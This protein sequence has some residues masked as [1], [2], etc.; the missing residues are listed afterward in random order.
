MSSTCRQIGAK[1]AL[2]LCKSNSL[3][4]VA[5]SLSQTSTP[6]WSTATAQPVIASRAA[7][8][9]NHKQSRTICSA[10]ATMDAATETTNPLLTVSVA[11]IKS[12]A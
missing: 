10:S 7:I 2:R 9:A 5:R 1:A 12:G 3:R 4:T 11:L 6:K 8:T